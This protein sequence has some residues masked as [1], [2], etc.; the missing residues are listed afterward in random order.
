MTQL[1]NLL[2]FLSVFVF[3]ILFILLLIKITYIIYIHIQN[4]LAR[5]IKI[6]T[7]IEEKHNNPFTPCKRFIVTDIQKGR[8]NRLYFKFDNSDSVSS[9]FINFYYKIINNEKN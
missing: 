8:Y 2:L 3:I 9:E 6:G 1:T 5:K 4:F 7:I